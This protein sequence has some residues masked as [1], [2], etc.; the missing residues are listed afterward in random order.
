MSKLRRAVKA[1]SLPAS[2]SPGCW[3]TPR[4]RRCDRRHQGHLEKRLVAA[5]PS[6]TEDIYK[7][8]AES[9]RGEITCAASCARPDHR[10]AALAIVRLEGAHV[11]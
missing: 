3:R 8:Y 4:Q 7:I 10:D 11:P 9:F 1:P 5:R 2:P 6:G